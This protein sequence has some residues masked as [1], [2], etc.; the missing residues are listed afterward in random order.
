MLDGELRAGDVAAALSGVDLI[1]RAQPP[2]VI[3]RL[4]RP[5]AGVVAAKAYR[6]AFVALLAQA[7]PWRASWFRAVLARAKALDD[8]AALFAEAQSRAVTAAELK[9]FLDRMVVAGR[10]EAAYTA[11]RRARAPGDAPLLYNAGFNAGLTNLPF[12]WVVDPSPEVVAGVETSDGA[13]VLSV[14]FLGGR[15]RFV[16]VSHYL[17]LA[18]GR[19][20]FAFSERA[21]LPAARALCWRVACAA[22]DGATLATSAPLS[23]DVDWREARV[24]FT[25]PERDCPFQQLRLE[26]PAGGEGDDSPGAAAYRDF[27]LTRR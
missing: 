18:P 22:E 23:G 1:L 27:A 14:D 20:E 19:Y 17:H 9:T 25:T 26:S 15:S 4:T 24:A 11:W 21:G 7:P 16:G 12:D 5:L 3:E 13:R 8:V 10:F 2:E 6:A